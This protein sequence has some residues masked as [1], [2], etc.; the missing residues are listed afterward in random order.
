MAKG[1]KELIIELREI[2]NPS[3]D[4]V[5]DD[6][7]PRESRTRWGHSR[8]GT[9]SRR[10]RGGGWKRTLYFGAIWASMILILN[11]A[12]VIWASTRRS[13]EGASVL[14]AG[15]CG[16]T[17]QISSWVHVLINMLS[18]GM[19]GAS[20][21][22]MQCLSAPAREDVDRAHAEGRWL[23]IGVPSMRNL[24]SIPRLRRWLWV[25]LVAS[26]VPLHLFYNST[27]YSTISVNSYDV[28]V[29]NSSFPTL[30]RA[31]VISA[32]TGAYNE[33]Y[34]KLYETSWAANSPIRSSERM[35]ASAHAN[36][37]T[38]LT[39]EECITAYATDW[40]SKYGGVVLISS[41]F[42][43]S[44][45]AIDFVMQQLA[46]RP[47][48]S[49]QDPFGWVCME[50]SKVSDSARQCQSELASVKRD[51]NSTRGWVVDGYKVD[52]CL[53]E[54]TPQKC[55]LEYSLT[56]SIV[57]LV[58]NG[59]KIA[60]ISGTILS[61]RANPLLT[62]GDAVASF[63]SVPDER[64]RG[65][66]L[67][68]KAMATAEKQPHGKQDDGDLPEYN[69]RPK[70]RW[71]SVSIER[72]VV[73]SLM[74]MSSVILASVLLI[75]GLAVMAASKSGLWT[76]GFATIDTRTMVS[77]YY[78][79]DTLISNS[80]IANIPHLLFSSL[81]FLI[82][83]VM[84]TMALSTEWSAF[85]V[86]RKG[87]RVSTPA[88]GSQR[89]A[90][91][92]SLPRRYSL[93]LLG[94]SGLLHWLMSQSIFLVRVLARDAY[95]KRD[96]T[97]DTTTVGWSPPAIL[98]GLCVGLLLPAGVVWLAGR[99]FKSGMPVAG[100]CS[101]AIAAA[102]HPAG[103]EKMEIGGDEDEI[104][105]QKEGV[106]CKEVQ[107]GVESYGLDSNPGAGGVGGGG[108]GHC[109]FSDGFVAAPMAGC[110]YQ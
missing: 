9:R 73:T 64:S 47:A 14:Y 63:L 50:G 77:T 30:Q 21:F 19:L 62:L 8:T 97:R 17:K 41:A 16:R 82:N 100:S 43:G 5:D 79:S 54:E 57:V 108:V 109:A 34:E 102:C 36:N 44:E 1:L 84:T 61:L 25:G 65:M 80:L 60:V 106:E 88:R 71:R 90:R 76:S 95:Q 101:L 20:H 12:L 15:D 53:V 56:L 42:N 55:T 93:P 7:H 6:N 96:T 75:Y 78:W 27:V 37:L 29:A 28:F 3:N 83:G 18:T 105:K 2:H 31:D 22:A 70:R 104:E 85:G 33:T 72:W 58:T 24:L 52:Y 98:T 10:R 110:A 49:Q 13:P 103:G 67:I 74:Y 86:S 89:R 68:T 40:Q 38:R 26:S 45:S 66:G 81:Y 51:A 59:V 99:F 91:F 35:L 46:P 4:D 94:V 69:P 107:W 32:Y 92:L 39:P 48:D 11:L 87:L 23:D